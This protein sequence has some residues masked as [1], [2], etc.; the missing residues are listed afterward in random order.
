MT[1]EAIRIA[2]F[3]GYLGDRRTAIDEAIAGDRVDV[4]MGDYLAEITLAALSAAYQRNPDRGFVD[5]FVDQL[6]PHLATVADRGIKVVTNAGGFHPAGLAA[7]LRAEIAAAGVE[8]RV[9]HVEGDNILGELPR[10]QDLGH[11]FDNLDGGAP[12]TDWV[13][14]PFAA[15]AYLGGWGVAAA[16][17][18]GADIVVCGR[19]TDASLTV[20]PAAWWHDWAEDD[21]TALAGGVLAGHI[22][23]CGAHAVGGN[24][25]GFL[26]I[27]HRTTPG[28]PIAEI[29][30]DG[31]CVITKHRRDG[32]AVT[33][34]T[35]TAQIMYEI[36]GPVYLNP[37]VTVHLD[38]VRVAEIGEDRV[39]VAGATGSPPPP[40]TKVAIFGPVGASVVNTVFVTSPHVEEKIGLIRDQLHLG[41][42][43][44]VSLDLTPSAPRPRTPSRSG[45]R[46]SHCG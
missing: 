29:A 9:A 24:F 5:Y 15:N 33:A 44:G 46:P 13:A 12:L 22:I 41:L 3:S 39:E 6:R 38:H 11:R 14:T 10:L 36:Q 8:L 37:D 4:L 20:G 40:T 26:D 28:F 31:T 34:D 23:E 43:E 21:W 30:A 27:P 7:A 45:P 17:R 25:S 1:R 2:N 42:P 19:V 16:L 18:D 35:V 32:G